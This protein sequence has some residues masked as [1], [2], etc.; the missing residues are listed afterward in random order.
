[1]PELCFAL[2]VKH[3]AMAHQRYLNW[4]AMVMHYMRQGRP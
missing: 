2:F 3:M 1:M 4:A